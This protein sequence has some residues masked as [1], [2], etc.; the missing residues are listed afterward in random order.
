[1]KKMILMTVLLALISTVTFGKKVVAK[2][3]TFSPLGT[4]KIE[5]VDNPIAMKGNDCQAYTIS[6]ENTPM[7]VTLIVCEDK[8]E[9]C[10]KYVV[11]SDKLSV[12]YVCNPVYFGVERLDKSFE[13]EGYKTTDEFLNREQYFHQK[14]LGPGQQPEIDAARLIAAYFPF[15]L[16][17]N[18]SMTAVK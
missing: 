17:D 3:Q 16:N 1:M 14:V 11:L 10:R 13:K 15:L 7:E 2:G 5:T 12:Q 9:K 18:A 8:E 4:Y 6:Y